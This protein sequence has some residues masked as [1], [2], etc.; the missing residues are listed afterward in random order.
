MAAAYE[1][2]KMPQPAQPLVFFVSFFG[3]GGDGRREEEEE[4]EEKKSE[5]FPLRPRV[6]S[7]SQRKNKEKKGALTSAAAATPGHP[8]RTAPL[9]STRERSRRSKRP[10]PERGPS[11]PRKVLGLLSRGR[12]RRLGSKRCCSRSRLRRPF[13]FRRSRRSRSGRLCAAW[14]REGAPLSG[15]RA[16]VVF[17]ILEEEEVE[18]DERDGTKERKKNN[19]S[20]RKKLLPFSL[21]LSLSRSLV[22]PFLS[23]SNTTHSPG[24]SQD[25]V[26]RRRHGARRQG[27]GGRE[28]SCLRLVVECPSFVSIVH[29]RRRS[30]F[31]CC[32]PRRGHFT[33]WRGAERACAYTCLWIPPLPRCARRVFKG[34]RKKRKERE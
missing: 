16:V 5:T 7:P 12:G 32:C 34:K 28:Q 27:P 31:A 19:L 4:E 30:S 24:R 15:G 33:D 25:L 17:F 3:K 10:R 13:A 29:R 22:P 1:A 8:S 26:G 9:A 11:S 2:V 23:N 20:K 14:R 6:L 21:S 18:G